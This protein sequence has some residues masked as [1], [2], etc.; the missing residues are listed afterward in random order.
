MSSTSAAWKFFT[1]LSNDSNKAKCQKCNEI[2]SCKGRNTTGLLQHITR[3]HENILDQPNK[4]K[5]PN[6]SDPNATGG[7]PS[8]SQQRQQQSTLMNFVMRT[9]MA[10]DVAKLIAVDLV[11]PFTIANSEYLRRS[12]QIRNLNLPKYSDK[13][14]DLMHQYFESA[15]KETIEAVRE[16]KQKGA[17][18][19]LTMDE[20]TSCRNRR[21]LNVNVHANNGEVFNLGLIRIA[22]KGD[23]NTLKQ[24][25]IQKL[26]EF[27]LCEENDIIGVTT[28]A[29]SVMN[30]LGRLITSEHHQCYNHGIHLAVLDVLTVQTPQNESGSED[31]D[32]IND[33]IDVDVDLDLDANGGI[34][35]DFSGELIEQSPV[36]M[37][38]ISSALG[39]VR[40][41]VRMFRR[42]PVKNA[43]LQNIVRERHGREMS[44]LLDVSTRWNSQETMLDRFLTVYDCV[45]LAL[46]ELKSGQ[47]IVD[48]I[49]P[50]L[51]DIL[52]ALQPVKLAVEKLSSRDCDLLMSEGRTTWSV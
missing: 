5:K 12:F 21:Y 8:V 50:V 30:K 46:I 33:D 44:L 2:L 1:K 14:M 48:D 39:R 35:V 52:Q 22:M 23:A 27:E 17:R 31:E 10:E 26:T 32:D 18:F 51:K 47:L 40:K 3:K 16:I 15:R 9:T 7:P 37:T 41:I 6:E 42:S 49:I 34:V 11:S 45:K 20:W 38:D 4:K 24:L 13:V 25:M 28:D 36:M 29:A 43:I 19:S